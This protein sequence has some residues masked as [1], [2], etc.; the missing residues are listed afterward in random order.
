M[1][2]G[3]QSVHGG[4]IVFI[5][6]IGPAVGSIVV[7]STAFIK[8]HNS[9]ACVI[10]VGFH[11]KSAA[12][13]RCS[14]FRDDG[15]RE[16]CLHQTALC[17]VQQANA[18]AFCSAVGT[19][20]S[21]GHRKVICCEITAIQTRAYVRPAFDS[22]AGCIGGHVVPGDLGVLNLYLGRIIQI[23]Q[24]DSAAANRLVFPTIGRVVFDLYR[25]F[26][27]AIDN[28][29]RCGSTGAAA[30]GIAAAYSIGKWHHSTNRNSAAAQRRF[31]SL[32]GSAGDFHTGGNIK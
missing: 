4:F 24:Q 15:V 29:P 18:A 26:F 19:H 17:V 7:D 31:I 25:I 11:G 13:F 30:G 22:A 5:K 2:R 6:I 1:C 20:N 3:G 16:V 23:C 14:V 27:G 21:I 10:G 28:Q 32:D 8:C 9:T 12:K